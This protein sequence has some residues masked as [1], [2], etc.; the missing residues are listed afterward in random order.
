MFSDLND[1]PSV[2]NLHTTLF[3]VDRNLYVSP[4]GFTIL[5]KNAQSELNKLDD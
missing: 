2:S 3:V 4:K 1:F 5:K